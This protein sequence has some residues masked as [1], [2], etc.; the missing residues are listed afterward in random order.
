MRDLRAHERVLHH[1]ATLLCAL[2][3][4]VQERLV[5][6]PVVRDGQILDPEV[7][8]LMRVN[9]RMGRR[10]V[11]DTPPSVLRR[12]QNE[13]ARIAGGLEQD[14][15]SSDLS[16]D[17]AAGTLRARHYPAMDEAEGD[18]PAPLLLFMHGGGFVFGD[19]DTHDAPCRLLRRHAGVHVLAIDYRLA[20]EHPFPAALDDALA[21]LAWARANAARLGCDAARIGVA[22]DS[23]GANLAAVV[24]QL[25]AR[26]GEPPLACQVLVYPAVDRR[27]PWRSLEAFGEGFFLTRDAIEWFHRQ[28]AMS[29]GAADDL[30]ALAEGNPRIHPLAA[31]DLGGLAPALVVTAGFDPLRDEGEAYARALREAGNAVTVRRFGSLV[32]GF[33]NM[34]GV[35]RACRDAVVEIAGATRVLAFGTE[36]RVGEW[37]RSA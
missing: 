14:G 26:A 16:I 31:E 6:G 9:E 37:R 12:T 4:S 5:G 2:P 35:S 36:R 24:A 7:A 22:G 27:T 17:G 10:L 25:S 19:L 13:G 34:V 29:G 28:Y 23:A 21:A 33:F 3:R 18:A 32:H 20:P 15:P 8:L 1:A 11:P 30:T